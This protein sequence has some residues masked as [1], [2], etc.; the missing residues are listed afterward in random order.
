MVPEPYFIRRAGF[1]EWHADCWISP[2]MQ[3]W[4]ASARC[5]VGALLAIGVFS[6]SRVSAQRT[7]HA[8]RTERADQLASPVHAPSEWAVDVMVGTAVPT[9][10]GG[11]VRIETPGRF[12]LDVLVGGN[13]YAQSLGDLV[14]AYGGSADMRSFVTGIAGS[15]GMMRLQ[16]GMRPSPDAGLEI[17]AGYSLLY[18][19]PTV[20]RPT[21]EAVTGQSFAYSGFES[22]QLQVMIHAASAELGWRFVIADH[23]VLRI[24]IGGTFT[25]ATSAHLDVS[26]AMRDAAPAIAD[27]EHEIASSIA[28]YGFMPEARIAIGYRF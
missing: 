16:V 8:E 10:L 27:V 22:T 18:S 3:I 21:L 4:R 2:A 25:F 14:Q 13:P 12:L 15:A 11:E 6:A 7:Q 17:L 24:G 20:T 23:L 19:S 28:R 26:Q 9:V 5:L 1:F